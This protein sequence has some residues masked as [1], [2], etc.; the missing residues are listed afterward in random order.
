MKVLRK[1]NELTKLEVEGDTVAEIFENIARLQEAFSEI[2]CGK[3]KSEDLRYVARLAQD[4]YK[5]YEIRCNSCKAKLAFGQSQENKGVIYPKRGEK[6]DDKYVAF[7]TNGWVK[8]NP[9]TG[10][11]E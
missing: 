9:E 6:Q 5:Y 7:G 3:C 10:K 4:K 2:R 11:E 1:I 8:Y